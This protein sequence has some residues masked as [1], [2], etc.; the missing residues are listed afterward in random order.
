MTS[1]DEAL[2]TGD[3]T[4]MS[5]PNEGHVPPARTMLVLTVLAHPSAERVGDWT[6]ATA[7]LS[8]STPDFESPTGAAPRP[9]GDRYLSRK[10]V[11]IVRDAHGGVSISPGEGKA[12]VE[13][14]AERITQRTR[15][16]VE[17]LRRGVVLCLRGRV[18]LLLHYVAPRQAGEGIDDL[19]LVGTSA[20]MT[21]VREQITAASLVD[22]PVLVTGESGAGK[23]LVA[24]AIHRAGPRSDKHYATIN[25]ATLSATHAASE[26]FGHTSG[27]FEG[28]ERAHDGGFVRADGGTLLVDEVSQTPLETQAQLLRALET[29]AVRPLGAPGDRRV[30]V[31]VIVSTDVDLEQR[32]DDGS[33]RRALLHR[34]AGF[35]IR[36]PALRQRRDDIGSLVLHFARTELT[37]LGLTRYIDEPDP[38]RAWLS[39]TVVARLAMHDWPGN[40]RELGNVV[41]Q[42]V[43]SGRDQPTI[44]G[45]EELDALLGASTAAPSRG[46]P[47]GEPIDVGGY[48]QGSR[49][50]IRH[51]TEVSEDELVAAMRANQWRLAPTARALNLSRTSLYRLIEQSNRIRRATTITADEATAVLEASGGNVVAAAEKLEVS[52]RALTLRLRSLDLLP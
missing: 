42:L 43:V 1:T 49:G 10:P 8:R 23:Q 33:F 48:A 24:R 13:V 39:A 52:T 16:G 44:R 15:F 38:E 47:S 2:P 51:P 17:Q 32:V 29:G 11:A 19:G 40:V 34:V 22:S 14:N 12:W 25:M 35:Q 50:G 9:L 26:L 36:V 31:R 45:G 46:E 28:A 18:T 27:A 7:E 20:E 4:T 21:A 37:K 30:D 5:P 3:S 6:R 41:R